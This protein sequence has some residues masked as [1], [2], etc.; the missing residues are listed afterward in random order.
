MQRVLAGLFL[1]AVAVSGIAQSAYTAAGIYKYS[2]PTGYKLNNARVPKGRVG[3]FAAPQNGYSCNVMISTAA[4]N[5]Y[6]AS[7]LGKE[8]V[9]YLKTSDKATSE[10]TGAA[11]TLGGKPAYS[12]KSLRKLP[13]GMNIRQEQV[14][15]VS[16]GTAVIL[17]FSASNDRFAAENAKF[18]SSLKS[19]KWLK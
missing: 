12:V 17:T 16:G 8:T 4:A 18:R 10:V 19:W 1:V 6:T 13:N 14:I 2:G 3:F 11:A 9:E 5:S 7:G 15:G